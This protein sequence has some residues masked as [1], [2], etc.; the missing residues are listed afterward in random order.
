MTVAL[1]LK[2]P[3]IWLFY[4]KISIIAIMSHFGAHL[5]IVGGYH[6]A[7]KRAHGIGADS[8]QIFSSPPRN[9]SL[10]EPDKKTVR[11]F[12]ET[13]KQLGINPVYFHA[14]YL[15]NLAGEELTAAKS[16]NFL[17]KEMNLAAEMG[18]RGSIIH[19]GSFKKNKTQESYKRFL[20]NIEAVLL[21]SAKESL[22]IIE[23]AGSRKIGAAVDEI[24]GIIKDLKSERVKVCLDT[25]HLWSAGYD[26]SDGRNL[27]SFLDEFDAKIG[28]SK[29][30]LWHCN[31]S[32]DPFAS[33]RDRH[34]NIGQGAIGLELFR[35]LLNN[36]RIN[37]RAFIIE[38]PGFDG[39]GPDKKNLDILKSLVVRSGNGDKSRSLGR[40][41]KFS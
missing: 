41:Q 15:V 4:Q 35:N 6:E 3:V 13:K 7:L 31:D 29:L 27:N 24:A 23:N 40:R 30:E 9:W 32:R 26:I 33:F 17:V 22:F 10:K 19:L 2:K 34:E 12:L 36:K 1:G 16:V 28:L 25:C 21:K 14:T 18:I 11:L 37:D 39:N 5:S 8:L 38:T 20:K